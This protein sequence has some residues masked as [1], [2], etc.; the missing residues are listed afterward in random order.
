MNSRKGDVEKFMNDSL[1]RSFG[2]EGAYYDRTNSN[3]VAWRSSMD[4][5]LRTSIWILIG[6][7]RDLQRTNSIVNRALN[8]WKNNVIG[9]SGIR[10]RMAL[11][12]ADGTP[13]PV[14]NKLVTEEWKRFS[15]SECLTPACD[16]DMVQFQKHIMGCVPIDGSCLIRIMKGKEFE[17]GVAFRILE[18]DYLD[19]NKFLT[20]SS[21][22][23]ETRFGIESNR[24]TG[25]T[26]AYWLYLSNPNDIML[27][28]SA[29]RTQSVRVPAEEIIF[30]MKPE[31]PGQTIG[32]PWFVRAMTNLHILQSYTKATLI[33]AQMA[34]SYFVF[35]TNTLA[36]QTGEDGVGGDENGFQ[37]MPVENGVSLELKKGQD[38]KNLAPPGVANDM[39]S[40]FKWTLRFIGGDLDLS[41]HA[42]SADTS[43]GNYAS[44]RMEAMEERTGHIAN[45]VW[46]SSRVLRP[47][48]REW[49]KLQLM[50]QKFIKLPDALL[51]DL[52]YSAEWLG[53]RW[54]WVD[55]K[56]ESTAA[57]AL[58]NAALMTRTQYA[59]DHGHDIDDVISELTYEQVKLES[60]GIIIQTTSG[61]QM[62]FGQ[63]DTATPG[64]P[65]GSAGPGTP[66]PE[67]DGAEET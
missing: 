25:K 11:R 56:N 6:R 32:A 16:M 66:D 61:Q 48:F 62:E 45:Q 35:I 63:T 21:S 34:A 2:F 8:L 52:L 10:M 64:V 43:Q 13:D 47:M 19:T 28:G 17:Y 4:A 18:I 44:L 37:Q 39:E 49:L 41:Y 26:V 29:G 31:R 40:L 38:V 65:T 14:T 58:I 42:F 51:K 59:K 12:K 60:E 1:E 3:W 46:F 24:A 27:G 22:P 55:P 23:T 53:R 36:P 7:C 20:D 30:V 5:L 67:D 50:T 33:K 15:H 57:V 54:D 9:P